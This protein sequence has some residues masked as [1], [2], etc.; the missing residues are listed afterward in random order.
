MTV[1]DYSEWVSEIQEKISRFNLIFLQVGASNEPARRSILASG[2]ELRT[3]QSYLDE[4]AGIDCGTL[5]ID[6]M[7]SLTSRSESSKM[8]RLREKIFSDLG[9]GIGIILLSR[10]PRV[11]FPIVV[12]SSLLDDASFTRAPARSFNAVDEWPSCS[13]DE[14]AAEKVLLN[15]V[16]ELGPEVYASLDRAVYECQFRD[17]EALS[18]L[19][20]RELEALDGAGL[21]TPEGEVRTWNIPWHLGP[22]KLALDSVLSDSIEAQQQLSSISDAMWKIERIIRREVRRKAIE[23][24]QTNWRTQCLKGDLKEKVLE[25]A[26]ESAYLSARSIKDLRDP[27]EW[28]SL[29]ELL[30]LTDDP[31][32]GRLGLASAQWR[33][34]RDQVVPIRNRLAHMRTLYPEDAATT[35]KW[36]GVIEARLRTPGGRS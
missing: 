3:V 7:E 8:G 4:G 26:T 1:R 12:G 31:N 27:L 14:I 36:R 5:I 23:C 15:T 13:E 35:V 29:G 16:V 20:A 34:F 28:L 19:K 9:V 2:A 17:S 18:L 22:L 21:T 10:S 33:Q 24:W 25:R 11:A 30:Q 6:Q 32:I